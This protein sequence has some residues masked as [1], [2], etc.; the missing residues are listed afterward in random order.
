MEEREYFPFYLSF[1]EALRHLPYKDRCALCYAIV[2]YGITDTEDEHKLTGGAAAAFEVMRPIL[3]RSFVRS[4][5]GKTPIKTGANSGSNYE[6]T[7]DQTPSKPL[8]NK[9]KK[10]NNNISSQEERVDSKKKGQQ[11]QSPFVIHG[12]ISPMM[13][14][15]ADRLLK[16]EA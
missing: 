3:H 7:D 13:K 12:E 10:K 5:A 8:N 4:K 15:A 16:E 1:Y 2:Q 11:K 6:Q 9:E 14:E